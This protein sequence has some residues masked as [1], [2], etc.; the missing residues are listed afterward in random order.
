MQRPAV[1]ALTVYIV[2]SRARR[3][4]SKVKELCQDL[5]SAGIVSEFIHAKETMQ[6]M[7]RSSG[8][9]MYLPDDS[10]INVHRLC[11]L[12]ES[13][14]SW[15]NNWDIFLTNKVEDS[16]NLGAAFSKGMFY[17]IVTVQSMRG[18]II[19]SSLHNILQEY[20]RKAS[21]AQY[22]TLAGGD[23]NINVSDP[24][25]LIYTKK[26]VWEL[27]LLEEAEEAP[28]P[29]QPNAS[30]MGTC[31]KSSTDQNAQV[32]LTT[33]KVPGLSTSVD[34]Q[35]CPFSK[36]KFHT[37]YPNIVSFDYMYARV[38]SELLN[39]RECEGISSGSMEYVTA[40]IQE[41]GFYLVMLAVIALTTVYMM[42]QRFKCIQHS[43]N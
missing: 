19:H 41:N 21:I 22:G 24:A 9:I 4:D 25:N 38:K 16:C 8:W 5:L 35:C 34:E 30:C 18:I 15:A 33:F 6:A 7:K 12:F 27:R 32:N 36:L 39:A 26:V 40:L 3:G 1:D 43:T 37:V 42:Y 31:V 10:C 23:V 29:D 14:K 11:R 20:K 28:A 17:S 2:S 13:F